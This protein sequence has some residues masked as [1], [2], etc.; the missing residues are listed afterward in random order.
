MSFLV[1]FS[2]SVEGC[3]PGMLVVFPAIFLFTLR[4]PFLI[5][6]STKKKNYV[7]DAFYGSYDGLKDFFNLTTNA[8][9]ML[10]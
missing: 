2:Y 4:I 6:I 1:F 9:L 8:T 10:L 7:V 3:T 5:F